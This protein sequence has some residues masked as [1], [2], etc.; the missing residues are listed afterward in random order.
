MVIEDK[1]LNELLEGLHKYE[2]SLDVFESTLNEDLLYESADYKS[3]LKT[4]NSYCEDIYSY[5][6]KNYPKV[7]HENI[8]NILYGD[9]TLQEALEEAE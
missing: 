3:T 2:N 1:K 6:K 9:M 4:Y 5:I 7:S 8:T